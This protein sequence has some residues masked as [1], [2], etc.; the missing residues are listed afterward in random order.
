MGEESEMVE[1]VVSEME[2]RAGVRVRG[3]VGSQETE[4]KSTRAR[5][6]RLER[7][8]SKVDSLLKGRRDL[9]HNQTTHSR[10]V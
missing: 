2:A 8:E 1:E 10:A 4:S 6:G 7:I 9:N 5:G 3:G